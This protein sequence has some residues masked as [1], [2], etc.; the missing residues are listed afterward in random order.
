MLLLGLAIGA[1]A[2]FFFRRRRQRQRQRHGDQAVAEMQVKRY[3]DKEVATSPNSSNPSDGT[4][5]T[6]TNDRHTWMSSTHSPLSELAANPVQGSELEASEYVPPS[7]SRAMK[8]A[9]GSGSRSRSSEGGDGDGDQSETQRML[10]ELPE[11]GSSV[12]N[13]GGE[14]ERHFRI[15][16]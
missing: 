13:T 15:D 6:T 8:S 10:L 1:V 7:E 14:G 4:S 11:R 3:S 9:V 12:R 5:P 16:G 2:F